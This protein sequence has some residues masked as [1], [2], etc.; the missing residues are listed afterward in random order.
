MYFLDTYTLIEIADG[1]KNYD[2]Y[3]EADAITLY[4][5]LGELY[6]FLLKKYNQQTADY[7]QKRFA[8]YAVDISADIIPAAMLFRF[9][10]KK[11]KKSFSYI[12]CFGYHF[13]LHHSHIFVTG[14]RAF[15]SM[16]QVEVVR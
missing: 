3:L 8:P 13:A 1:N 9:N 12:D 14:D 6:F 5:N 16:E 15:E 11:Q 10:Q 4:C 2:P 7:F